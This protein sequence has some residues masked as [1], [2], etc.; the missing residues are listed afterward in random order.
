MNLLLAQHGQAKS[1]Q[2]DADRPLTPQGAADADAMARWLQRAG[3]RI[4]EIRHSGK[5]RAEQTA[6]RFAE[7]LVPSPRV[8]ATSGLGPQD[9]VS[10]LAEELSAR[11]ASV[12]IV[13]H[14]PFLTRLVGALVAGDP[15]CQIVQFHYAGVVCLRREDDQWRVDWAM[16]P[17]LAA[18][19]G[20]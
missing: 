8:Q 9:D 1:K 4:P 13:G 7:G 11:E 20:A 2:E 16:T 6:A 15:A 3:C 10:A 5:T 14:L 12:L 19:T 17:E 18:R